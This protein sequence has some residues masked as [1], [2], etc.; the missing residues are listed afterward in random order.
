MCERGVT[1]TLTPCN[2]KGWKY[3]V[4]HHVKLATGLT[5]GLNDTS[6]CGD[7]TQVGQCGLKGTWQGRGAALAAGGLRYANLVLMPFGPQRQSASATKFS[8]RP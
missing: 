5:M 6:M 8:G 4:H 1:M 7:L 2:E 3:W